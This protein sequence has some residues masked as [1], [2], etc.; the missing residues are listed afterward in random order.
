MNKKLIF[1]AMPIFILALSMVLVGCGSSPAA[2]SQAPATS[3]QSTGPQLRTTVTGIPDE[4]NG[5]LGMITFS[6][7]SSRNDPTLA[8]AMGT[9]SNS[10]TT[11]NILDWVTDQPYNK[12][13]NYFVTFFVYE[14]IDAAAAGQTLWQGIIMSK[15]IGEVNSIEF[16]EFTKM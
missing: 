15:D 9:I 7:G 16:S 4:H 3:V 10:S 12:T 2:S 14:D 6:A 1:L 11:L 8:W 5:K 13:G